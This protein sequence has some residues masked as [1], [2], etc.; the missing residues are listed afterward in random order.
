MGADGQNKLAK[1]V[2]GLDDALCSAVEASKLAIEEASAHVKTFSKQDLQHAIN[3]LN[4]LETM[5]LETLKDVAKEASETVSET[6]ND[7]VSHGRLS[8]TG[9][10]QKATETAKLLN[11]QLSERLSETVSAGVDSASKVTSNL[12]YAAAGFLEAI[13]QTLDNKI[14]STSSQ[15]QHK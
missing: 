1:A 2:A 3:D 9:I 5:Y 13:A 4:D 10:G 15:N 12:A 7:L 11:E 14:T 6:L 8:G